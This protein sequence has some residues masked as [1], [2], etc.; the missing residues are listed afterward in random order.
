MT[1]FPSFISFCFRTTYLFFVF[2]KRNESL[3]PPSFLLLGK[4]SFDT[5]VLF[6]QKDTT[7]KTGTT[8]IVAEVTTVDIESLLRLLTCDGPT[9]FLW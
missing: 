8:S 3:P 7:T 2:F 1:P 5:T 9:D 4:F 6:F